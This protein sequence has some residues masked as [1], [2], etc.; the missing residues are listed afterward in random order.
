MET[1]LD[2]VRAAIALALAG[3]VDPFIAVKIAVALQGFWTQR[4]YLSEGRRYVRAA[5]ALPAVQASDL[6]LGH[7]LYVGAALA[8]C[9]GD[10]DEARRMLEKCLV[11]RRGL[12]NPFDIAATLS[13]LSHAR[14]HAGEAREARGPEEEA[15]QIFLQLG[16]RY[17]EAIS[18]L[19]LGQI[20]ASVGEDA[21]AGRCLDQSLVIAREIK[22]QEIESECERIIGEVALE[23]GNFAE[24]SNRLNRALAV[25][26]DTGDRGGEATA[27]WW[28]GKTDI[29]EGNVDPARIKLGGSL[30]AFQS[31]EMRSEL[32]GCLEDHASL[33]LLAG[34]PDDAV[35]LCGAAT[36]SRERLGL[37]RLPRAEARRQSE[38]GMMRE[39]LGDAAFNVAWSQGQAWEIDDAVRHALGAT[40]QQ[41][42]VD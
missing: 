28:L 26:H 25:C 10:H 40:G 8:D 19:H 22:N 41:A 15:L 30:R 34:A 17:G 39:L 9:Q 14:M 35:R 12:E 1:E 16:D 42:V 32:V 18:R 3:R 31:L 37:V 38:L 21:E 23:R 33:A 24:A 20:A 36:R 13:T 11:L 7:A 27:L 4:G 2:N 29:A 6:A 5:L